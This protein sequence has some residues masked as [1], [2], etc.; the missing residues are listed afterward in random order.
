MRENKRDNIVIKLAYT[1]TY[2]RQGDTSLCRGGVDISAMY[3]CVLTKWPGFIV[4]YVDT[5]NMTC[6]AKRNLKRRRSV[7]QGIIN[8]VCS[9]Y[10]IICFGKMKLS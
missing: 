9:F 4:T 8:R 7:Y 2:C 5:V 1:G 10:S 3:V 6:D